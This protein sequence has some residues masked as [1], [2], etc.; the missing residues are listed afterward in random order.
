VTERIQPGSS[1]NANDHDHAAGELG[2]VGELGRRIAADARILARDELALA[3][4]ELT[5][6]VERSAMSVVA[7]VLGGALGLISLSLFC[8][9][10]VVALAPLIHALWLRM[11][12]MSLAYLCLASLLGG[13][14]FA[15]LRSVRMDLPQTRAEAEQ[16]LHVVAAEVRHD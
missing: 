7:M 9:T 3:K 13:V 2:A 10:A 4:L 5:Q 14:F 6:A 11:L 12:I 16:T 15:R 8:V 1:G